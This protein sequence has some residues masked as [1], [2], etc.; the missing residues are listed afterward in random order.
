M[1]PSHVEY[2]NLFLKWSYLILGVGRRAK[3]RV[4][5]VGRSSKKMD[6]KTHNTQ[7]YTM[8]CKGYFFLNS[9]VI[10]IPLSKIYILVIFVYV[11]GL[12]NN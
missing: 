3:T 9:L 10:L 12:S 1:Y 5:A 7:S 2:P 8:R 4:E 6:D 11:Y